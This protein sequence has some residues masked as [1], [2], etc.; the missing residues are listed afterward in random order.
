MLTKKTQSMTDEFIS[1]ELKKLYKVLF[2]MQN[3]Q[4]EPLG[5]WI[6]RLKLMH[7]L[8]YGNS[9]M[10]R[11]E[12]ENKLTVSIIKQR[13]F[14]KISEVVKILEKKYNRTWGG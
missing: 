6:G 2:N 8:D 5:G 7:F 13:K 10:L 11:F 9:Q 3:Q 14:Y 4:L 12:A 1:K